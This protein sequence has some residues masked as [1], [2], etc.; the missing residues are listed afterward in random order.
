MSPVFP[1]DA[2][3]GAG[4]GLSDGDAPGDVPGDGD[5]LGDGDGGVLSGKGMLCGFMK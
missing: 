3:A 2:G 4:D 1:D 5:A